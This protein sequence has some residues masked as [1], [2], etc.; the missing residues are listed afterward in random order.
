LGSGGTL[1]V[2]GA[3]TEGLNIN[4]IQLIGGR[5]AIQGW[6]SGHAQDSEETLQFAALHGIKALA[7]SFSLDQVGAAY[8]RML[9]NKA[10]FRVSI[11][12]HSKK[13][14]KGTAAAAK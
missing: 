14:S 13:D 6:P 7:E 8:D 2:L 9:S 3:S 4:P 11:V 5:R 1:L 10:R 12:P